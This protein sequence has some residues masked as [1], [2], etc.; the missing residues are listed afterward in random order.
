[1]YQLEA[2]FRKSNSKNLKNIMKESVDSKLLLRSWN[3]IFG[4][5]AKDMSFSFFKNET[6][7]LLSSNPIWNTEI[8]FHKQMLLKKINEVL[9]NKKITDIIILTDQ[10]QK[11]IKKEE[12]KQFQTLEEKIKQE[13]KRK[14]QQGQ[15]LCRLCQKVLTFEQNCIFCKNSHS[16]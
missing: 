14:I 2:I 7:Y 5:L 12:K 4:K 10:K 9:K 13:N 15:H 16:G 3:L 1:M 6:I 8:L 11:I